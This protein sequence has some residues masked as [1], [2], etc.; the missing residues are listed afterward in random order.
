MSDLL[1]LLDEETKPLL[2]EP[3]KRM[4]KILV[5]DDE[6]EVHRVTRLVLSGLQFRGA[7]L[8]IRDAYSGAEAVQIMREE[9]DIEVVLLDIVMETETAGWD[10]ARRIRYELNNLDVQIIVSTGYPGTQDEH[11]FIREHAIND[12]RGKGELTRDRMYIAISAAINA[13]ESSAALRD[14]RRALTRLASLSASMATKPTARDVLLD[15]LS[16]FTRAMQLQDALALAEPPT[17][18]KITGNLA[19]DPIAVGVGCY[20]NIDPGAEH[21]GIAPRDYEVLATGLRKDCRGSSGDGAVMC[22]Q[23]LRS[24][25]RVLFLHAAGVDAIKPSSLDWFVRDAGATLE[26]H[27][28]ICQIGDLVGKLSDIL[29]RAVGE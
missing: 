21:F 10:V 12:Y 28:T 8:D 14:T 1:Q 15:R 7:E 13:Y 3:P 9:P 5:V 19:L 25:R 6:E 22:S 27:A 23:T 20:A 17:R 24:G 26:V 4:R 11:E 29:D 2:R 16:E 18:S